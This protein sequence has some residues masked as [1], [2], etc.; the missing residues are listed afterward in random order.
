MNPLGLTQANNIR[1]ADKRGCYRAIARSKWIP[2]RHMTHWKGATAVAALVLASGVSV[3]AQQ[4]VETMLPVPPLPSIGLPL[5]RIGLPAVD[6]S[7]HSV[8]TTPPAVDRTRRNDTP[9]TVGGVGYLPPYFYLAPWYFMPEAAVTRTDAPAGRKAEPTAPVSKTGTLSLEVQPAASAQVFIDGFYVGTTDV[10]G[11]V[12]E[13]EA[14]PHRVELKASGYDTVGFDVRIVAQQSITYRDT[15]KASRRSRDAAPPPAPEVAAHSTLYVIPGC[16]AGNQPP[17]SL[18]L[19]E[20]CDSSRVIV[21][22]S[23]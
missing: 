21:K 17:D 22:V 7:Q 18:H 10:E 5:P 12:F 23:R 8:T 13:L 19:P 2:G 1:A 14:G 3:R 6:E 11:T 16:Y 9:M 20:G 4:R 15:L